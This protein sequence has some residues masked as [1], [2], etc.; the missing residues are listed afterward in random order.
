MLR[1]VSLRGSGVVRS[2]TVKTSTGG[3]EL[4]TVKKLKGATLN[5]PSGLSVETK[6]IGR[7]TTEPIRS[8]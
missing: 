1:N 8:L 3:F 4:A 6:A 2:P 5:P 7:G